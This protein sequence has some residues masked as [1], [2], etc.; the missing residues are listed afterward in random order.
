MS[1]DVQAVCLNLL[2]A[3]EHK[4]HFAWHKWHKW[5]NVHV[6]Q[7]NFESIVENHLSKTIININRVFFLQ[8]LIWLQAHFHDQCFNIPIFIFSVWRQYLSIDVLNVY[9]TPHRIKNADR[10]FSKR[11]YNAIMYQIDSW[12]VLENV[13][14]LHYISGLTLHATIHT[15]NIVYKQRF[16]VNH[17]TSCLCCMQ[18][19][20]FH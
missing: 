15:Y 1:S 8:K 17:N 2:M 9:T 12:H 6:S 11:A 4:L 3:V 18:W 19:F 7:S 16:N 10:R 20:D 14:S 13:C 5:T